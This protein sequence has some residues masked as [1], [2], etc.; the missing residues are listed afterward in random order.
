[1]V[2][3]YCKFTWDIWVVIFTSQIVGILLI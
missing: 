2:W 1:M 3:L